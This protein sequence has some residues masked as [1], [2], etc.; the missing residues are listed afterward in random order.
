MELMIYILV[1]LVWFVCGSVFGRDYLSK[2]PKN[3]NGHLFELD[4][5]TEEFRIDDDIDTVTFSKIQRGL[6][7]LKRMVNAIKDSK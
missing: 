4:E 5:L 3:V 1:A 2:K 6:L 7:R